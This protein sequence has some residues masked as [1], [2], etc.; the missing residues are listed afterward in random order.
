MISSM[1]SQ[2]ADLTLTLSTSSRLS[3][4]FRPNARVDVASSN[5]DTSSTDS[6]FTAPA[7]ASN[8]TN[9]SNSQPCSI[10]LVFHGLTAVDGSG[11]FSFVINATILAIFIW[12]ACFSFWLKDLLAKWRKLCIDENSV[13]YDTKDIIVKCKLDGYE[14]GMC[15][16]W[17]WVMSIIEVSKGSDD[18]I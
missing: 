4:T 5:S 15:N 6:D 1:S 18:R 14:K 17:T 7:P 12:F 2:V 9:Q 3:S 10:Q 13:Y 11:Q 16:N 8:T